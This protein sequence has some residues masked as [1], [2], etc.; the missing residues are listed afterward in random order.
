MHLFSVALLLLLAWSALAFGGSPTWAAAATLVLAVATGIL[1]VLESSPSSPDRAARK[2]THGRL[3]LAVGLVLVAVSFQLIPFPEDLTRRLSPARA[4]A[5]YEEILANKNLQDLAYLDRR[6]GDPVPISIVPARTLL[7]LSGLA[8]LAVLLFGASRGLSTIGVRTSTRSV[9]TIGVVVTLI[10]LY[11][12]TIGQRLIYGWYVP[13]FADG[14]SA[15]FINPNHDAGWLVMAMSLSLGAFAG[16]IASGQRGSP[17]WR[18]RV[19]WLSTPEGSVALLLLFASACMAIGVLATRARSGA[20]AMILA[21]AGLAWWNNRKQPTQRRRLSTA[22]VI[23]VVGL[24]VLAFN[25]AEVLTEL[26]ATKDT[27][28]RIE[29]WRDTLRIAND[30]RLSGTGY[31]T[32]GA[33]MLH[34]Q[35]VKGTTHFIE[36]HNEYLQ[37]AAEGGLLLCIPFLILGL[38]LALEI[39][40]RFH[41]QADDSRTYWIRVGAVTGIIAMALQSLVEFTLQMPGGAVMFTT[42]LAIAIHRPPARQARRREAA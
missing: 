13:L 16:E 11:Q 3:L 8:G 2:P 28:G 19:I 18:D 31:N 24:G 39:R 6:P 22:A 14:R 4:E 5:D 37:L 17:S 29:I 25:G 41:E 1:G 15:P 7:G 23:A 20:L 32:Y 26:V 33:A 36:A 34:H 30:F 38:T 42:L 12:L 9:A 27:A 21:F 10:L 35:T 40:R